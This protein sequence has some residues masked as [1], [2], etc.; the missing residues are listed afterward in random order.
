M[1]KG[2][3]IAPDSYP[4]SIETDRQF[5]KAVFAG[6]SGAL[7]G[8]VPTPSASTLALDLTAGKAIL[9]AS[10][11][12]RGTYFA[13]NDVTETVLFPAPDTQSR[14]DAFVLAF[15]DPQ[16]GAV[17]SG[18]APGPQWLVVKGT[19][20]ATP[21]APSDAVI[22][23]AVGAGSWLRWATARIDPGNSVITGANFTSL[24]PVVFPYAVN[25]PTAV[26]TRQWRQKSTT[27]AIAST[28]T[29][30]ADT[31]LTVPVIAGATYRIEAQLYA[32]ANGAGANGKL[33][34]GFNNPAGT[35]NMTAQGP[36]NAL[37]TGSQIAGEWICRPGA[38]PSSSTLPVGLSQT[39]TSSPVGI[40]VEADF[41]CTA[42]GTLTLQFTQ[43]SSSTI[44]T[45]LLAGSWM[46]VERV[47]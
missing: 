17:G 9:T 16:Y 41:V 5:V 6:R 43:A 47:A 46:Q 1:P 30:V 8:F 25:D 39:G 26:G 32:D 28:T 4:N 23:L 31:H 10:Q 35:L 22:D 37:T 24:R 2:G 34:L 11:G 27:Q 18:V 12:A 21:T 13:W 40:R 3:F 20:G 33:L 42:S 45:R 29:W 44:Q 15:G 38:A 19:P 7:E 14:I 36:G